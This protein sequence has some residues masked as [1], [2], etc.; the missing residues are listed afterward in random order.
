MEHSTHSKELSNDE[1]SRYARQLLMPAINI[2]GQKKL[3]K[4]KVLIVG[5]G[6]LGSPASLYL[7]GAG[8][9]KLGIMD[10]DVV[11]ASNMHR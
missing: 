7:A 10:G 1:Y 6:G 11:E 4:A 3:K 9:G 2:E 8:I 5:A